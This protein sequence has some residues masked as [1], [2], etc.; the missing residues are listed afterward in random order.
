MEMSFLIRGVLIGLSVAAAVGPMSV[1]CM[2]RTV[3][4]GFFY[5]LVSGLGV[6]TADGIYG[7]VA[8]FGLTVIATFLV[9]QQSWVRGIGGLFLIYLGCRTLLTRPAERAAA[10]AKTTSFVGAYVSTF[11]L[12]LTN[13]LTI[14]SFVAIFAGIGVGGG[15]HSPLVALLVVG[16]V[17]LG[18]ASWWFFLT[19]GISLLRAKFTYRWLLWINR[20]SGGVIAL[21]GLLALLSLTGMVG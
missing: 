4:R 14:L 3:H 13:P 7:C 2:Q 8:G 19:G 6:A 18:S 5:G 1:L 11:L 12:T 9:N 10:A 16:G 20:L 21:F 15:Q 17:F